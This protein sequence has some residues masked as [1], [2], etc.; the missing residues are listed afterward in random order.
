MAKRR[1]RTADP[2]EFRFDTSVDLDKVPQRFSGPIHY[3][4]P[5]GVDKVPRT[6]A[7]GTFQFKAPRVTGRSMPPTETYDDAP[8]QE[9]FSIHGR[10]VGSMNEWYAYQAL[11]QGGI[12]DFE[13]DYQV[14]WH[15]GTEFGG[16]VLDFVISR[17]GADDV[18]RVMGH[19]WHASHYGTQLDVYTQAQLRDEGYQVHDVLDYDL[20]S[21]EDAVNT[22]A[23]LRII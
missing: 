22:L 17:G 5:E 21:V 13:I 2:T 18:L 20:A 15:G 4:R 19:Y 10:Q 1:V 7:P 16:Q 12:P 11:L 23:R 6:R 9:V 14:P 8:L 3:P